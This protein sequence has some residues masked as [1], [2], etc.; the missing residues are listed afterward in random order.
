MT[1]KER[2]IRN[3]EKIQFHSDLAFGKVVKYEEFSYTVGT[4]DTD[5]RVA[6]TYGKTPFVVAWF[7]TDADTKWSLLTDTWIYANPEL[8]GRDLNMFA[9]ANET[10]YGVNGYCTTGATPV[11]VRLWLFFV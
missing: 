5:Y 6:H 1:I 10:S 2:L 9:Y 8:S 3:R 4:S 7:K 11:T